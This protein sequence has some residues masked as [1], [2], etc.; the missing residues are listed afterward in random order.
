MSF[1][2]TVPMADLPSG[3]M[4]RFDI[5]EN[6]ILI[7]NVYGSIFAMNDRCGHMNASLSKGRLVGKIVECPLHKV[8]YDVTTGRVNREPKMP[9]FEEVLIETTHMGRLAGSIRTLDLNTYRT[10]VENGIIQVEILPECCVAPQ[11]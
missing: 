6:E 1:F 7:A 8:R 10:R 11:T 2:N 5:G 3:Q 4:V 9:G